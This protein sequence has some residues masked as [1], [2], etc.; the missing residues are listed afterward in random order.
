[1]QV[2]PSQR[3]TVPFTQ[4]PLTLYRALRNLNPSP[5][6]YFVEFGGF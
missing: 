6:L 3:M 4:S 2:V 1:M 5:Y